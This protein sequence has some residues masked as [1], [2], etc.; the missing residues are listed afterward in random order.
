MS[1]PIERLTAALA[2]PV[3]LAGVYEFS[4]VRTDGLAGFYEFSAVSTDDLALVLAVVEAARTLAKTQDEDGCDRCGA[5]GVAWDWP[6]AGALRAA[7][8][9]IEGS[10]E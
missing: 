4:A 10:K 7:L 2:H 8:A 3:D 1:T 9:A 6:D 5:T